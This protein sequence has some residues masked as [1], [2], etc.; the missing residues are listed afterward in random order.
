MIEAIYNA[1]VLKFLNQLEKAA[2]QYSN[3]AKKKQKIS[4]Y[5]TVIIIQV[6]K[7]KALTNI[8]CILGS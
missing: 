3:N 6:R 5:T 8:S 7:V 1:M 2:L 4:N